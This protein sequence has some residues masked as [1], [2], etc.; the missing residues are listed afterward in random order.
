MTTEEEPFFSKLNAWLRMS[1]TIRLLSITILVL[2]LLI[3]KS[4]ITGLIE[5]RQW[6]R[7]SA[8][9]EVSFKWGLEQTVAGPVLSMPYYRYYKDEDDKLVRTTEYTHF[10]PDGLNISGEVIPTQRHRGIYD[11]V[12]YNARLH[13]E[14]AFPLPD[15]SEWDITDSDILWEDASLSLGIPDM[16]G[17]QE[18]IKLKWNDE[19]M[20]FNPG[21]EN[22]EVIASGVS[23][24]VPAHPE[25]RYDYGEVEAWDDYGQYDEEGGVS[26][27]VSVRVPARAGDSATTSFDFSFDIN[28]NGSGELYFIPLGK[29]TNVE[30]QSPWADPAFDGAFLPDTHH[31]DK[32][33]FQAR[34]NVLHL[35]RNY[36]QKWHGSGQH[37]GD[38]A[39]GVR[40]LLPVDQYLK[41]TRSAKYAILIISLTFLIFFFI[42]ILNGKRIHP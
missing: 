20:D 30:L 22:N 13:M 21:I 35:N 5:E 11:I 3:P 7:D 1:V 4:M 39:F 18:G 37:I 33:G 31:V 2:L 9:D 25:G 17:I 14:G 24:R 41:S 10:L 32:N 27:G 26:S 34:W 28:L 6:T 40:L 42:E 15:F 8:I 38:S 12:V 16:R 19:V 29:E 23:T 36:P